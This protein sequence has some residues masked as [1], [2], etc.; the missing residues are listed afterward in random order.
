MKKLIF[1]FVAFACTTA[2]LSYGAV[3][4]KNT[5]VKKAAPVATKQVDKMES[6]AS[7][8]PTVISLVSSAKALSVQQQQLT[9]E[10]APTGSE[11]ETVNALVKEWAKTGAV[12]ATE[13][14]SELGTYC[15]N[16]REK[17]DSGYFVNKMRYA[18]NN[19]TCFESFSSQKADE[20][21]IWY[22][23]PKASSGKVCDVVDEKNCKNVSNIY[24]IFAKIPFTEE[25]YTEAEA[26]K[27]AKLIE[28][29]N[30]CAPGKLSAARREMYGNFL[31]QTLGNLGQTTGATGTSAVLESVSGLGGSGDLKSVLPSLGQMATQALDK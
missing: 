20:E 1:I 25:D 5:G 16:V 21:M 15:S 17:N 3:N 22:L 27:I 18:E 2:S 4:V 23:F 19:E 31:T 13:A 7:L 28:K 10:C 30:K 26:K 29:M 6:A 14:E 12:T 11:I 24:D 9:A 8:L